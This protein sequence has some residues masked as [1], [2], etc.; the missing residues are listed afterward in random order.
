MLEYNIHEYAKHSKGI[1]K[2]SMVQ[3]AL[4]QTL[5]NIKTKSYSLRT[6]AENDPTHEE[7]RENRTHQCK[8]CPNQF[9]QNPTEQL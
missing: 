3:R 6:I 9:T 7:K 2:K 1:S 5:H 4:K 8:E